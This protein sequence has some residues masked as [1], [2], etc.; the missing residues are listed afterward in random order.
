MIGS[1]GVGDVPQAPLLYSCNNTS[2]R[3]KTRKT[4]IIIT[5]TMRDINFCLAII[6]F[7]SF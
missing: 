7:L 1:H 2:N 6:C 5:T 4:I 3:K